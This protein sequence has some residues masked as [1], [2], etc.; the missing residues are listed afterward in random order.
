MY[1]V[2]LTGGIGSGKSTVANLFEQHQVRVVDAD[3]IA[4]DVVI[5]GS[6]ALTQI[7]DHFGPEILLADGNLN[8]SRLRELIFNKPKEKVWLEQ[9]LHPRI[10][11]EAV[12]QIQQATSPYCIYMAPLLIENKL[13]TMVDRVLVVD[14]SRELQFE[15]ASARDKQSWQ[16]VEKIIASQVSREDRLK[17]ADDVIDNSGELVNLEKQVEKL[18]QKYCELAELKKL[19]TTEHDN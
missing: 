10:R 7:V 17:Y 12:K 13:F 1:V 9:L 4:R 8:R 11:D 6:P 16:N 2:G 3:Q 14:I 5:P 18:H 15:R 19:K